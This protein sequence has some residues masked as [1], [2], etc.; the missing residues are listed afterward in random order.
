MYETNK[1]QTKTMALDD[2]RDIPKLCLSFP[3]LFPPLTFVT[4]CEEE[5][6]HAHIKVLRDA[7]ER[8]L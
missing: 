2:V 8:K 4:E 3:F 7:D 1:K 5:E 6:A